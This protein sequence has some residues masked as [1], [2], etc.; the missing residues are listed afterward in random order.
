MKKA[1]LNSNQLIKRVIGFIF[2]QGIILLLFVF[3]VY[4][5]KP[6]EV[7]ACTE[8]LIW[9]EDIEYMPTYKEYKC[10]VY[11]EG[12]RYDFPN[13]GAFSE[14][15]GQ[16]LYMEIQPGEPL[17]I[18]HIERY[19][20]WGKYN[21]IVNAKGDSN[22]YLDVEVYNRQKEKAFVFI[23]VTFLI[24]EAAFLTVLTFNM[25]FKFKKHK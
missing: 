1:K 16:E 14:Y 11:A 3:G 2:V 13:L 23:L 9:V 22:V 25:L 17:V 24:I 4:E 10:R 5:S 18:T 12:V 15:T 19:S 21:L 6:I 8:E 20:L 7:S